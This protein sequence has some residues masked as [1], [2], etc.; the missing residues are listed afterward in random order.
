MISPQSIEQLLNAAAIEEVVGDYVTLKRSGSRY[1]GL[2]PF[3]DEKTPSFVVTPTLGIYKCFGC[4]KGGNSIHFLME[5]ENQN[6]TEAARSLAKRYNI[7]LVE[8][9]IKDDEAYKES[10]KLREN[11]Q[12][13]LDFAQQFFVD[14]LNETEEGQT[15]GLSY[16]RERGFSHD[17]I[18]K[19][20]LGYSP[21]AW[22]ALANTAQSK[23]YN[24]ETMELAGLLKKRDNGSVYDL[25]R[26]RVIF[27][28]QS[29]SGKTI[30]F[31]GRKMSSTDPAPKY[32]NSPETELYKKSEILYG[33]F[34]AKNAIKKEDKVYLTEGYTDVITLST[35]GIENVVASSGTALTPGQIRLLRRFTPNITVLYDGDSAGIK[36]SLR[37]I[38]LLLTEDLNV[39]VVALPEGEDP[40][41]YCK[42]L[43]AD[44]FAA[45]LAANEKNF[46][47]FKADLLLKEVNGDPIRKTEAVRDILESLAN[48][49]D[50]LKR[51]SLNKEL[52]RICEIDE[53]LLSAE[54]GKLVRKRVPGRVQE[55]QAEL[56][57]IIEARGIDMPREALT[58]EHQERALIRLVLIHGH[59]LFNENQTV[60]EMVLQELATDNTLVFNDVFTNTIISE[61][62]QFGE[63]GWPGNAYFINHSN[64]EIAAWAA[65]I[66]SSGYAL[67]PAYEGNYIYI[68]HENDNFRLDVIATFVHLRRKKLDNIIQERKEKLKNPELDSEEIL[69]QII[70]LEEIRTRMS[71]ELGYAD[72]KT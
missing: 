10:Q 39:R 19:W 49:P 31:A 58:D 70:R 46:I 30:A 36:A 1:K 44:A 29:V 68:T 37:G 22:E 9:G 4:Q 48:I 33:I 62:R 34:Q 42:N 47:F 66:L 5:M 60:F 61:F 57:Q 21:T 35:Y 71:I 24:M 6:F 26:N 56:N 7:E 14:S 11:I 52:A 27:P 25:F 15:I 51:S 3:H 17:V 63:T 55:I 16:F 64:A 2:C 8:T 67:S 45:Y 54:L 41:S 65:G 53:A 38:D 69:H 20:G 18:K 50:P 12:I 43:G 28:I 23:G 72:F 32:V 40:D 13:V 59:E